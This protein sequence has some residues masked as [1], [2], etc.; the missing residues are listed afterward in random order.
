MD[1]FSLDSYRYVIPPE[2]VAQFPMEPRDHARLLV[3][4][5]T[6][7]IIEEALV[8]D[9]PSLLNPSD[10]LIFNN[11]RVLH[12]ALKGRLED[13]RVI[14][15]LL[16][17]KVSL[18]RWWVMAKPAKKLHLHTLVAFTG[19]LQARVVEIREDGQ[20][21]LEFSS[22]VTEEVLRSIG[23]VPLPPYIRRKPIDDL[24][25]QRYQTIYAATP[26]SIAAPTAGLHFTE[27]LFDR[28][29]ASG[30]SRIFV[31]LHVG[32]GTF[33]PVRTEDIRQHKMHEELF[34]LTPCVADAL[35]SIPNTARRIAVGTTSCRVLETAADATGHIRAG[36]GSTNLFIYPG[37]EFKFVDGLFTNF[38]TPESSLLILVGAFM[39]Y[40]L[41]REAYAKAIEKGFRLFSYGDAMLI[42]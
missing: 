1:P 16:T 35:N 8:R 7:G 42:I 6:S 31:T 40:E 41:L 36:S 17:E 30:V 13:T 28:L 29:D 21:L 5:K 26:G 25:P 11:T 37:Y 20:R 3:V 14:D 33:L 4:H 24:D 12:A 19:G 39:G 2:L 32:T 23:S 22:D 9:L 34:S 38:H 18:R 15:V 10:A 27:D